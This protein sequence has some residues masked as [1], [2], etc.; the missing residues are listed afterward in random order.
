LQ[1]TQQKGIRKGD[2][3][4]LDGFFMEMAEREYLKPPPEPKIFARCIYCSMDIY[5]FE[6]E[7]ET[8]S[9]TENGAVCERCMTTLQD[10][11]RGEN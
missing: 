7:N 2:N 1:Y 10:Y 11:L 4:H 9:I 5:L 3:L 8:C 6:Q